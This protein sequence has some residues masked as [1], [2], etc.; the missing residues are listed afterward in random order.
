LILQLILYTVA[1]LAVFGAGLYLAGAFNEMVHSSREADRAF[2]NVDVLLRQR[3]DEIP[4][5]VEVCRGYMAHEREAL[6]SVAT[7]RGRYRESSRI[8]DKVRT[9]NAISPALSRL[10]AV[11]E[12]Y[13]D[14][15]ANGLFLELGRRLTE[16]ENQ[17]ADRRELFN[18]SVTA[19]NIYTERLPA[20]LLA[21]GLGFRPRPLLDPFR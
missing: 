9:E 6:E 3:H 21:R 12:A 10:I 11:A 5:L 15:K 14:L 17:I 8:D 20:L 4:R 2:A 19:Y 18:A 7:L 1:V 13:P 16:L